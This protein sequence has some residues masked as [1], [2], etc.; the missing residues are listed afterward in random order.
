VMRAAKSQGWEV[1]E[2][3]PEGTGFRITID[4]D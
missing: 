3:K 2:I 4:K 1:K